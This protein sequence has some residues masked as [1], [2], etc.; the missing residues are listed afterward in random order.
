RRPPRDRR[1]LLRTGSRRS[2]RVP[3]LAINRNW[4]RDNPRLDSGAS[5]TRHA[6]GG[7]RR[8]RFVDWPGGELLLRGLLARGVH[9]GEE[10]GESR[11]G[12][13]DE[14]GGGVL[15]VGRAHR[16][17]EAVA[18]YV[19]ADAVIGPDGIGGR[20]VVDEEGHGGLRVALESTEAADGSPSGLAGGEDHFHV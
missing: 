20:T 17:L 18:G 8:R 14:D 2:R 10:L 6:S 12:S 4:G 5:P 9:A 11:V 19:T 13:L 1:A 16:L 7:T 3:A 15:G